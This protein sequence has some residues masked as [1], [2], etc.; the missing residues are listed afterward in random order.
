MFICS[1]KPKVLLKRIFLIALLFA[2]TILLIGIIQK[3]KSPSSDPLPFISQTHDTNTPDNSSRI[4]FL[5]RQSRH[6]RR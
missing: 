5:Q 1:I 2:A 6:P 3:E 4:Q